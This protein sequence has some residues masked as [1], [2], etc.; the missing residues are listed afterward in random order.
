MTPRGNAWRS[1]GVTE[2]SEG[3]IERGCLDVKVAVLGA[4]GDPER[5][6]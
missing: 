4:S 2:Y 3:P 6:R 5:L 1:S